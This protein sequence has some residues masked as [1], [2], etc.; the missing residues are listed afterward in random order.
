MANREETSSD[1]RAAAPADGHRRP[2]VTAA[3]V[4]EAR[5]RQLATLLEHSPDATVVLDAA[6]SVCEW[7]PAAE[8]LLGLQRSEAVGTLARQILSPP[9][10]EQFDTVWQRL[11]GTQAVPPFESRWERRDGS[12]TTLVVTVA[13]IRASGG[14]AG[15]V[16]ILRTVTGG[17]TSTAL[18]PAAGPESVIPPMEGSPGDPRPRLG[19]L[20]RD[21]LTGLPGRRWLQRHLAQPVPPGLLRG[22]AAIDVDAFA[23]VNQTYGPDVA[24]EILSELA[25]RLLPAQGP[26]ILGRWQADTFVW[27]AD[28]DDPVAALSSWLAGAATALQTPFRAGDDDVRLT[29]SSGLVA[30]PL[31]SVD[32]LLPS[33]LDA[34]RAAKGT[35]RDRAVWYTPEMR[36]G[37][38]T[39]FRLA[40][41]LHHGIVHDELRLHF[42]PIVDLATNDVAGV[43]A[44]VRW[45]RPGV[46]LL[47]PVSFI[48]VAERTGQIVLLGSWVARNAC[49]AAAHLGRSVSGPRSVSI[50]VSARQLSE[51]GLV[52]MLREAVHDAGRAPA[53]VTVEVTES[54]LLPDLGAVGATLDAIK[55]LGIGLDLDDFGTGYSSLLHLKHFPVDRIKIDREFVS[56]LGTRVADTAIVASTIALAHSVGVLAVAEGVETAEQLE[57][58]RGMGCDFAQGYLISRPLD[59]EAF[60]AWLASYTPAD[61]PSRRTGAGG[62]G[63]APS[64][65]R[66]DAADDRD[67]IADGRDGLADVREAIADRRDEDGDDRDDRADLRDRAAAARELVADDRD[68]TGAH[69]RGRDI[70]R[71]TGGSSS[72]RQSAQDD[73]SRATADRA[74][75]ADDRDQAEQDRHTALAGRRSEASDRIRAEHA[76]VIERPAPERGSGTDDL[77]GHEPTTDPLP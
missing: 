21:E 5:R 22:V 73:R 67:A 37:A 35:G 58:L 2:D 75:E 3:S 13:P 6:G 48:E 53:T 26:G 29:V 56:G 11:L 24:D 77:D 60:T 27:V 57:L 47:M 12:W 76:R 33:A 41:D 7:N 40:N 16:A 4:G 42:Q 68:R 18:D 54:V 34:L 19:V 32:D 71:A 30:D 15:A 62:A 43:E 23:L 74:T 14:L 31:S 45:E 17:E 50:N 59:L 49:L 9:H 51:P 1:S 69:A 10:R 64:R 39:G 63:P 28:V 44:L 20:E 66:R 46:G 65:S 52:D 8:R 36:T 70:W 72:A 55:A 61:L 38:T 25:R